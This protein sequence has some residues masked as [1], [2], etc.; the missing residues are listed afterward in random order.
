MRPGND[1]KL[2]FLT[3]LRRLA[4]TGD[5]TVQ[6]SYSISARVDGRL[7]AFRWYSVKRVMGVPVGGRTAGAWIV[8]GTVGCTVGGTVGRHAGTDGGAGGRYF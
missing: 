2:P 5:P 6:C 7:Y 1:L 3:A 4:F 8:A